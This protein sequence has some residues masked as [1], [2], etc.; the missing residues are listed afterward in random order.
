MC[1]L[2]ERLYDGWERFRQCFKTKTR[3]TSEN[4]YHYLSGLLRMNTHRHFA[5]IGREEAVDSQRLQHFMSQS[6][7]SGAAV[8]HQVRRE[9]KATAELTA[10][11]VLL[12]DESAD[13][14]AGDQ[15]AGAGRQ[16]NGRMGKVEMS[17]V[18]VLLGYVNLRVA[19]GFWSWLDG[20][21]FL[22]RDWFG[23]G[24]QPLRERLGVP[25][26]R[27]FQSKVELAWTMIERALDEAL[28][29]ACVSFDTLYGRSTALRAQVR[30][31]GKIYLA[32]VP[33]DTRV[34]REPPALGI[35]EPAS[36]R[37]RKPSKLQVLG[38][39]A[40]RVDSLRA[41]VPWQAMQVR[42]TERG[43]VYDPFA[44]CRVWTVHQGQAVED[45]LVMR[46]EANGKDSYALCNASAD[47]PTEVL[48]WWK[49]QRYFI[50]RSNQDAK[51]ELGWDELQARKY[52][53]WEHHVALT[54]LASWFVAQ[55]KYEWARDYP[56]DPTLFEQLQTEVLP[57]LSMANVRSLLRAVMPLRR[58]DPQQA[59][60]RVIEHLQ[61]RIRSRNSRAKKQR[62]AKRT[63]AG[64][65]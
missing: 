44:F 15:S 65:T 4:A 37:G 10:G 42:P 29:F 5:G 3:D 56:R 45:W 50:E 30:A 24:R 51:S 7:W 34:Y 12:V 27:G 52:L 18:G 22:P 13:E 57:A 63:G 1:Q 21:L 61:N 8:C 46:R 16:Y 55:T 43:E 28:P 38:G 53:A 58:L 64:A 54:V 14:K 47:T 40:V 6:P 17:Q 59:T 41:V 19:Q 9:L 33:A 39:E 25:K 23:E 20:E 35:P 26:E 11:G 36:R 2:G 62:L 48:A 49:C 60:Q 32:E 31:A